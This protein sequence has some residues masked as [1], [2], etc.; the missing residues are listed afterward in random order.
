MWLALTAQLPTPPAT[1]G[2]RVS[3]MNRV[4]AKLIDLALVIAVS[5]LLPYPLGPLL[6]FLYSLLGDGLNFGPFKGQSIG[7][8]VMGLQVLNPLQHRPANLKDSL[9]RNMPVGVATF[10]AIIP[11]WGWLILGLIGIPLMAMEI[12]LMMTV[13]AGHRLGDVMGD[14]E[15]VEAR[16]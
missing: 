5:V 1:T 13:E 6:G 10:F 8:K 15:V 14:T 16:R 4:V 9:F 11:I 12:Y 3:I 2:A 7:K